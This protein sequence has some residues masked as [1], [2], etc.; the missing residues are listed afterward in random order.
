M[1]SEVSA[2]EAMHAA[3]ATI[4]AHNSHSA[5]V[6]APQLTLVVYVNLCSAAIFYPS[7]VL[8]NDVTSKG[9]MVLRALGSVMSTLSM[10]LWFY[11]PRIR[12]ARQYAAVERAT[13]CKH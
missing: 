8:V 6:E 5:F 4:S 11:L 9:Y 3:A 12:A 1:S 10:V 13:V 7:A 2:G